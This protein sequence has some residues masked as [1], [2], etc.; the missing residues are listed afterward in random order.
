MI[1]LISFSKSSDALPTFT[2]A[3]AIGNLSSICLGVNILR[4]SSYFVLYVASDTILE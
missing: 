2:Y 4:P 1:Y 3:R